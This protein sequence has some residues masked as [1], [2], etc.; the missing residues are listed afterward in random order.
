MFDF[1]KV[2]TP[3]RERERWIDGWREGGRKRG[4]DG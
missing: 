2:A 4:K 3:A 1:K